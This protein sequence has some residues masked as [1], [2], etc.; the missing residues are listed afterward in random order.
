M[1]LGDLRYVR[2]IRADLVS[3]SSNGS[4]RIGETPSG[5]ESMTATVPVAEPGKS[6]VLKPALLLMFGRTLAFAATFFIPVVL[7]RIFDPAHFGAY[8]QLFLVQSTVYLIGQIG[9]AT[10][11]YYFLPLAPRDAGRYVANSLIFLAG[12]GLAGCTAIL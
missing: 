8:K 10:T 2:R 7:A 12:A 6:A 9:M 1:G 5:S 11:L 3:L 4:R